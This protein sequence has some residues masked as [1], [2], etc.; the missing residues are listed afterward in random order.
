MGHPCDRFQNQRT[1]TLKGG[2][3]GRFQTYQEELLGAQA[4]TNVAR[5]LDNLVDAA[6]KVEELAD[7]ARREGVGLSEEFQ[8][9]FASNIRAELIKALTDTIKRFRGMEEAP[10]PQNIAYMESTI[11][12]YLQACPSMPLQH[13]SPA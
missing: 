12:K 6:K 4:P 5:Y 3:D 10:T 8:R 11:Q 1:K 13:H 2:K 9:K 7:A